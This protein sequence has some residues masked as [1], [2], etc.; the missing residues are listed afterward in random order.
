MRAPLEPLE[1]LRALLDHEVE[2]IVIG[3]FALAPYGFVRAT[4]DLD[5]VLRPDEEN[6]ER[7][8]AFALQSLAD[9]GAW[10]LTTPHGTLHVM[11][12][13]EGVESYNELRSGANAFA[14]PEVGSVLFAGREDLIAMK[15]ASGR[16]QDKID[17][18]ALEDAAGDSSP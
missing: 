14:V 4:D 17:I 13:V 18:T 15:R 3:G 10:M 7:L 5:V 11:Q 8:V 12:T 1:L 9:G 6:L 16:A 2:F